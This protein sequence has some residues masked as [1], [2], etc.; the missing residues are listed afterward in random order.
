MV[1]ISCYAGNQRHVSTPLPGETIY[2]A[3]TQTQHLF[4]VGLL[5]PVVQSRRDILGNLLSRH[6][7]S[8]Q[9]I[10][11]DRPKKIKSL[12]LVASSWIKIAATDIRIDELN[13]RSLKI[14]TN[15]ETKFLHLRYKT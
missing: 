6:S 10:K 5:Q 7:V 3:L 4:S 11:H 9:A 12:H 15:M 8:H 1:F 14:L 13:C 2:L